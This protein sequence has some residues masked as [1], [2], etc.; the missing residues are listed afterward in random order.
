MQFYGV[1]KKSLKCGGAG[2]N[3]HWIG[4][5]DPEMRWCGANGFRI[6]KVD[7]EMR[8]WGSKQVPDRKRR[9]QS[10]CITNHTGFRL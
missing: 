8:W 6:G 1:E 3:G 10:G 7:P 2:T 4:K 9:P 5:A